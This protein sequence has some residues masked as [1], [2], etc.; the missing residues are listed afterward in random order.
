MVGSVCVCLKDC[1]QHGFEN[2]VEIPDTFATGFI[3]NLG[4]RFLCSFQ[5][6]PCTENSNGVYNIGKAGITPTV[7]HAA[8]MRY[9]H[10]GVQSL[11]IPCDRFH[12]CHN[13][14]SNYALDFLQ[15]LY[16]NNIIHINEVS[17]N[18]CPANE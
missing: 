13:M 1:N 7:A 8:Q 17:N 16:Q 14:S 15:C 18:E 4:N 3:G 10:N 6:L 9:G 11:R 12:Q 2:M 5:Q